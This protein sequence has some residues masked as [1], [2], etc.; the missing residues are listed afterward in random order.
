MKG[1]FEAFALENKGVFRIGSIDCQN[2]ADICKKEGVET[3]PTLRVYPEF[4]NPH[5]DFDMSND[6]FEV[7]KLK[8]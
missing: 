3:F 7:K 5:F 6:S 2:H 1:T 4:P 8:A